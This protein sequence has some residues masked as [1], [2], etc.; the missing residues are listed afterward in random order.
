MRD[1]SASRC[2]ESSKGDDL[3]LLGKGTD[4][5]G[6]CENNWLERGF[7]GRSGVPAVAEPTPNTVDDED[8]GMSLTVC[9]DWGGEDEKGVDILCLAGEDGTRGG[10]TLGIP[11]EEDDKGG[12]GRSGLDNVEAAGETGVSSRG[13]KLKRGN[14]R[15]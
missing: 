1:S 12:G 2:V 13:T 14:G 11:W 9:E 5:N 10:D 8:D 3:E 4:E 7:E 15:G 6:E